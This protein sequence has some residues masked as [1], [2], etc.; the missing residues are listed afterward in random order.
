MLMST[1]WGRFAGL[2]ADVVKAGCGISGLYDLEPIRLSYLN[3]TLG[4]TPEMAHRNSP[5]HLVPAAASGPLLLT[6]GGL[7][8]D[9]YHRQTESLAAAWRRRGLAVEVMDMDGHDHF[10]I[11]TEL[12]EPGA[13]LSQAILRQ[14]GLPATSP[15]PVAR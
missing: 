1:D 11:I 10:S 5:V 12:E 14:M 3:D 15:A 4:L 9:E 7:E 2:P 6:V 13:P 8:G